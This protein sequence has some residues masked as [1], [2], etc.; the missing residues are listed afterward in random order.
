MGMIRGYYAKPHKMSE[1]DYFKLLLLF[2]G[3]KWCDHM[4]SALVDNVYL[5]EN[6]DFV[7][8]KNQQDNLISQGFDFYEHQNECAKSNGNLILTAPTGSG[9]TESAF[10][11][12]K[13]KC[14][15]VNKAE[16]FI[17]YLL[18]LLSMLCMSV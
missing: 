6:E 8:L 18:L 5:I 3:L 11:W 2:G 12:L 9:K 17:F 1:S 7:F 4:G 15:K 13:I 14:S 16:Y 10:L